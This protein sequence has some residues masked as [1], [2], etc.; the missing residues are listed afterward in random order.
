[1]RGSG[2]QT[3]E[4]VS[5]LYQEETV[6]VVQVSGKDDLQ[7]VKVLRFV[8]KNLDVHDSSDI[9]TLGLNIKQI[10]TVCSKHTCS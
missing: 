4:R 5:S 8:S 2:A 7:D 9:K 10:R 6:E 1:M 3:C